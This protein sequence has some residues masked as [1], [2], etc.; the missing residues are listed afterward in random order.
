M[1]KLIFSVVKSTRY[2]GSLAFKRR[3]GCSAIPFSHCA[4]MKI[5][6]ETKLPIYQKTSMAHRVTW[7]KTVTSIEM[8]E[9]CVEKP[10]ASLGIIPI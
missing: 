1:E 10:P 2:T 5:I 8:L 6:S 7:S 4:G 3:S 9:K